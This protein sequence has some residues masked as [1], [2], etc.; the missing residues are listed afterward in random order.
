MLPELGKGD[1]NKVFVIPSEFTQALSN[2]A[3]R[4]GEGIPEHAKPK[5]RPRSMEE[6]DARAAA[7][8]AEAERAARAASDEAASATQP[9]APREL[10]PPPPAPD[11]AQPDL[12]KREKA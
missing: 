1:A 9:G 2:L 5:P 10:S 11:F 4:F 7:D 3:S 12:S 8:A 6:I